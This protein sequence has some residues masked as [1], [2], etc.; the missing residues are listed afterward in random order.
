[1]SAISQEEVT[2]VRVSRKTSKERKRERFL[3]EMTV[4]PKEKYERDSRLNRVKK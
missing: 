3:Y 1:M 2:T 4:N